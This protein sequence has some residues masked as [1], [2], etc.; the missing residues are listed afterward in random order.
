MAKKTI[1]NWAVVEYVT[2]PDGF[3]N[4]QI[5]RFVDLDDAK[6]HL[7]GERNYHAVQHMITEEN[8]ISFSATNNRGYKFKAVIEEIVR[9]NQY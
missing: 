2:Y 1:Y 6:K 5:K 3:Q 7:A 4:N 9:D 8:E